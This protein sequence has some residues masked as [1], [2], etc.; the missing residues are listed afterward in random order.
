MEAQVHDLETGTSR[1]A[2]VPGARPPVPGL[3]P[4]P[5]GPGWTAGMSGNSMIATM[6]TATGL[7]P[8]GP[9]C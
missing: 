5:A 6:P 3:Y 1:M 7:V 2:T 8:D 9:L 4:S